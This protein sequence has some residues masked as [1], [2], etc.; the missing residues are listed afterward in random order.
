M[1]NTN[2]IDESEEM[3]GFCQTIEKDGFS[4][5]VRETLVSEGAGKFLMIKNKQVGNT[6]YTKKAEPNELFDTTNEAIQAGEKWIA[7]Q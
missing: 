4:V 6:I 5:T 3:G 7:D 2:W 1:I